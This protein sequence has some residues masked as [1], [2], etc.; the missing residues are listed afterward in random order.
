MRHLTTR[1]GSIDSMANSQ[2]TDPHLR[3]AHAINEQVMVSDFTEQ[4][5]RILD[6]ILRLS[7][8]C[9]KKWAVIP[10]Q[11]TF[12]IVGVG[13]N[14]IKAHLDWLIQA[15]VIGREDTRYWFNK[16]FDL[17]RV[18]R[19]L[20]YTPEA[21]AE[22]VKMNLNGVAKKGIV[23]GDP[24]GEVLP[25]REQ[26]CSQKG[27][28]SVAEKGTPSATKTATP[29]EKE[30]KGKESSVC[31]DILIFWNQQ[32]IIEHRSLNDRTR[33]AITTALKKYS[34]FEIC[35]AIT[36]W[37]E[38]AR[39]DDY[40]FTHTGWTLE[41]FL[42]RGLERFA[43]PN[44]REVHRGSQDNGKE[45]G[46]DRNDP[47]AYE[48]YEYLLRQEVDYHFCC[49]SEGCGHTAMITLHREPSTLAQECPECHQQSFVWRE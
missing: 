30:R 2:P 5:R 8:G 32:G 45:S 24:D 37:L 20:T 15:N 35:T 48:R 22:L 4:Q 16:D 9:H 38:I 25:K 27:N 10:H 33:T 36:T 6:L 17:W 40:W 21:M 19:S 18:S 7:W 41:H 13:R 28:S 43:S 34:V 44:A 46:P 31:E 42:K 23:G 39:S 29:K 49:D 3:V 14:K 47:A 26:G 11:S 12:E 1:K